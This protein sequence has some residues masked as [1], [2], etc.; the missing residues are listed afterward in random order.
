MHTL[1]SD[2]VPV[3]YGDQELLNLIEK[4][5][6]DGNEEF[7]YQQVCHYIVNEAKRSDKVEGAPTTKYSS[8][9]IS[10]QDG[11]RISKILWEKIWDKEIFIAF[12]ENPYSARYKDDVRFIK[13]G[14]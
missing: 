4:F 11:I 5:L 14:K 1:V 2:S 3:T 6:S 8:S 7:S 12:G 9:D 13:L 10:I